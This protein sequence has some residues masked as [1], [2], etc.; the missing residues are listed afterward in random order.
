V[1][2]VLL[3]LVARGAIYLIRRGYRDASRQAPV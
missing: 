1:I 2:G 3:N